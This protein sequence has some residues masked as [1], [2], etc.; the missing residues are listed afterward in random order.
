MLPSVV[1]GLLRQLFVLV[2]TIAPAGAAV[3]RAQGA[4][5]DTGTGGRH[6]IEGRIYFPSGRKAD[7]AGVKIS[8]ETAGS[9]TLTLFSDFN[10]TF[11]FRNLA[12]GSYT[13]VIAGTEEYEPIRE[14]VYIDDPGSS[15]IRTSVTASTPRTVIV[16]I[17]L[18]PKRAKSAK[19]AVLDASLASVPKSAL[20]S[21]Y[22]A[23]ESIRLN[24]TKKAISELE[25]AVTL[26]PQFPRALN[27]LGVQYLKVGMVDKAVKT[28]QAAVQYAPDDFPPRLNY[29]IALLQKKDFIHAEEQLR[30][31]LQKNDAAA[32]THMYLGIALLHQQNNNPEISRQRYAEAEKE[33]LRAVELGGDQVAQAHYY[34]AGVYWRDG[35]HRRAADELEIYLKLAPNAP[36]AARTRATIKELRS[37]GD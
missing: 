15:S 9:G 24:D 6:T 7:D 8:L 13:V 16:P 22:Q 32:T 27:E 35:N 3:V 37:R 21:Y 17:Y 29:G 19:P 2:V 33:L 12:A 23:I 34:L 36:D 30:R 5:D 4:I 31:A 20:D 1:S 26:Y 14:S 18:L 10:G 25:T 28:L 11:S